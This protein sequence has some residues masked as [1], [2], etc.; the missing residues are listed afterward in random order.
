VMAE[1]TGVVVLDPENLNLTAP[2][3]DWDDETSDVT[4]DFTCTLVDPGVGDVLTL[5][6]YSDSGLTTLVDT[7]VN[8]LDAGE[9]SGLSA[10]FALATLTSGTYYARVLAE[11]TGW[12]SAYSN[13]VTVTIS[14]LAV[15]DADSWAAS[16]TDILAICFNDS[17]SALGSLEIVDS[18]TPANDFS[19]YDGSGND[20]LDK[21]SW[22]MTS[23]T[24][25][26]NS[27]GYLAATA[28]MGGGNYAPPMYHTSNGTRFGVLIEEARTNLCLRSNEF[29]NAAWTTDN[30]QTVTDNAVTGPDNTSSADYMVEANGFG[31]QKRLY[32][33]VLTSTNPNTWSVYAKGNGRDWVAI[34]PY[35][36][37]DGG[38]DPL[39]YFNVSTGALGTMAAGCTGRIEAAANGFYRCS[40]TRTPGHGYG[41]IMINIADADNSPTYT[42]DNAKGMYVY[43]AQVEEGEFATSYIPTVGSSVTR[44]APS[45]FS[46]ADTSFNEVST[47]GTVVAW[48]R[49][50]YVAE[51]TKVVQIDNGTENERVT[52]GHNASAA[53]LLNVVDGSTEQAGTTGITS[54]TV[55]VNTL[56]KIAASYAAN[57]LAISEGGAA[58]TT[59]TSATLPTMTTL[60]IPVSNAIVARVKY[61]GRAMSDAE[62]QTEST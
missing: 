16:E 59:D 55:V 14:G 33:V 10:A 23:P 52:I 50:L 40:V 36:L 43:G 11:R 34:N 29:S 44:N 35:N 1:A 49:P 22:T 45:G 42:G 62:L 2:V 38:T 39:C 25:V 61:I 9:V 6:L 7:D 19:A 60:K 41:Y 53:A 27:S 17:A 48:Y 5:Q 57:D 26:M 31:G 37:G 15:S 47:A 20:I 58:P 18:V 32:Q 13:T 30:L 21:L 46:I 24:Y 54:G 3:L 8:T 12:T 28:D 4:P 51:A 56:N